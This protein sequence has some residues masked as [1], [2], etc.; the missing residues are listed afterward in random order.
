MI[1]TIAAALKETVKEGLNNKDLKPSFFDAMRMDNS[2]AYVDE[3]VDS[4]KS[5]GEDKRTDYIITRNEILEGDRHPITGVPF[6]RKTIE[7]PDG[8]VE[9]VFPE[10]ESQ[11]DAQLPSD[12]Y[13]A[14]DAKQ[15]REC[16]NQLKEA[17]QNNPELAKKFTKEQLEQI[18]N[19]DTPDGYVWHHDA[20]LG[21]MQLVDF[22][23]HANTGHT[24]GRTVWGGG[25]ENR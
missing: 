10:F 8:K 14:S 22:E 3:P 2:G 25:S 17:V 9:G 16:N 12:L 19:G 4:K 11:F 5:T 20:E 23:T 1:E 18:M 24:G 21:K 13:E 6:E 7:T 15:F